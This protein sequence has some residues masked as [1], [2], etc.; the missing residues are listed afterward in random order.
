MPT[1]GDVVVP[2]TNV[3]WLA[4]SSRFVLWLMSTYP[5]PAIASIQQV[6]REIGVTRKYV[7][8]LDPCCSRDQPNS[9]GGRRL[10]TIRPVLPAGV[11]WRELRGQRR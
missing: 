8:S 2:A 10:V 11:V 1:L 5:G 9:F 3:N 7:M 6:A 4:D